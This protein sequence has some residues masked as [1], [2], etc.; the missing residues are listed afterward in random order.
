MNRSILR[1]VLACAGL[2][3]CANE[4]AAPT[5]GILEVTVSGLPAGQAAAIVVTGPE[6]F[7]RS[8][9]SSVTISDLIPGSYTIAAS[10]VA[11]EGTTY[12]PVIGSQTVVVSA[13]RTPKVATVAY[14]TGNGQLAVTINGLPIGVDAAVAVNGPASFTALLSQTET[15]TALQ[16]GTYAI[17][18]S[19]VVANNQTLTPSPASQEAT[20]SA[21]ATASAS[22]SYAASAVTLR[23]Q[24]IVS[25]LD[26]PVY[27]TA[28]A[29]DSRLFIVEQPGRIRI[30]KNGA[31]LPTPFLDVTS[32]VNFGGERGL[33]SVAF[34]P[35]YAS[36][37]RFYIY[38]TGPQ[39]DI[40]IDRHTVS[41]NPDVANTAF[42]QVITI[43][44]RQYSNHNGG[45]VL[46]GPDGMLYIATGDG[47]AGGDPQNNGQN[48][49]SL[50]GK[51]L[52]IDVTSLPYSIPSSNPFVNTAG[53][54]EIWAYG[55]RNPW[56]VAFDGSAASS[57]V[58]IADVGQNAWEEINYADARTAGLN[59][60]WR[61]MEGSHCYNPSTGCL[62]SSLTL[63]IHELS[64][65]GGVCSITGGFVYRGSAIPELQGH[66]FYSD[67]CAGWLKSFRVSGGAAVDHFTWP[68]GTIPSVTSFGMDAARELYVLSGNG[69]VYR[70]VRG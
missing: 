8:V 49:N 59:Y 48:I 69:R 54:D 12:L 14:G 62:S 67:Y 13:S 16:T 64:H 15:L 7:S 35:A 23:L 19:A 57:R 5:R 22:V 18:A 50:L 4:L 56:R 27:L 38:Y 52:R 61:L 65:S 66:Y 34:D 24:E 41:S 20:V 28:P 39:G 42:D 60:G 11:A 45:H 58:Y 55:L 32:K 1:L 47:G 21:G 53:A 9:T 37:G 68:V 40:F 63:P 33:L 2:T 31:L 70:V 46:F 26:D 6:N 43:Q 25:G 51:L 36:N 44:H 30:V 17:T 29:N 3:A 10:N